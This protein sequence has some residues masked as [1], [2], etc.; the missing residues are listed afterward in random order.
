[1]DNQY[2]PGLHN[3]LGI[4]SQQEDLLEEAKAYYL[5]SV[6]M[7]TKFAPAYSNLA[8]LAEAERILKRPRSIGKKR[9]KLGTKRRPWVK[10]AKK[11]LKEINGLQSSRNSFG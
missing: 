4:I 10:L 11:R 8:L 7:L 1:M 3:Q 5:K 6:L 2:A 9:S